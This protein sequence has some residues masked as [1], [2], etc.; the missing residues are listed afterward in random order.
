MELELKGIYINNDVLYFR[1]Q[2][3]NSSN[4]SYDA[5]DISFTIKDKQKSKRTAT[6]ELSLTPVYTYNAFTNVAADS[7]QHALSLCQNLHFL[8]PNIYPY[9]F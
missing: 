3:Q 7:P 5:D 9:K 4:V 8:I 2:L 6:Q 1:L